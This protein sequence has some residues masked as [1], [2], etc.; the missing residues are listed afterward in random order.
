MRRVRPS[1][2]VLVPPRPARGL[3]LCRGRRGLCGE[4]AHRRQVGAPVP[5]GRA[6]PRSRTA[7]RGPARRRIRRRPRRVTLIRRCAR[8]HGLPA[9]AIG[10]ALGVPRSTVSAWLRRLGLNRP[11]AVA[12][13]RRCS[14]TS[15]R[16]PA[17]SS[18]STS[19]PWAAFGSVG[20]RIHG[21]RRRGVAG[22]RLGVRPRGRRRSQRGSRTS[23]CW[24]TSSG[25]TLR[26]VSAARGRL[27]CGARHPR[28]PRA[29]RQRQ[30]LRLPRLPRRPARTLGLRHRRTRPYTPRTNGKAE[31]FI[32]TL[33]REWAYVAAVRHVAGAPSSA[34]P[35]AAVLQPP[36]TPREP[37]LSA[38]LVTGSRALRDEQRV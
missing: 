11:P 26:R 38:A 6:W 10:R 3:E 17:T 13:P 7:R 25:T 34:R 29:E 22:R 5:R 14:A 32:Q 8:Q 31:R 33:L 2:R 27:V 20:H 18:T 37:Q 24:P 9:W 15:G 35:L 4:R 16:A 12:P 19:S 1:T 36:P 21:D 30:R 23:R 28:P